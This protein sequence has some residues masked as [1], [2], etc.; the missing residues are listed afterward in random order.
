M[1]GKR[2]LVKLSI[3]FG[4]NQSRY[5]RRLVGLCVNSLEHARFVWVLFIN[6]IIEEMR[7]KKMLMRRKVFRRS[8]NIEKRL[9]IKAL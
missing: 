8:E 1:D 2:G 6:D 4:A 3:F 5:V 7:C 9:G